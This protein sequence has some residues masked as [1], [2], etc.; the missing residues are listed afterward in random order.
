MRAGGFAD[1]VR[2][3]GAAFRAALGALARPGLSRSLPAALDPP[4]PLTPELA[5][6]ALA[7]ADG[8]T[9]LWLDGP[10]AAASDVAD[11]LRF[12][13]G[14]A[15]VA[16]PARAAFALVSDPTA[17]LDLARF[18]DGTDE[19]P[20]RSATLVLALAALDDGEPFAVEGPGVRGI[21]VFAA[22]PLPPGF[23]EA[24]AANRARFPR[25]IDL[26]LAAPGRVLGL[27]RSAR[28]SALATAEAA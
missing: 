27:P 18:A 16:D 9:P 21:A 28:V 15:I 8:D 23:A 24:L 2:E 10:L 22:R 6:L 14:A 12:H 5:A 3:A 7:L 13:T 11:Y 4:R 19:Y 20:D 17:R 26:L 25:G 1:P